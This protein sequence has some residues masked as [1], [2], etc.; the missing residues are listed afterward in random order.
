[1]R[2]FDAREASWGVRHL[3]RADAFPLV[4]GL[5]WLCGHIQLETCWSAPLA[6]RS[7][8]S[9]HREDR[10]QP[11]I[12]HLNWFTLKMI[13]ATHK[14]DVRSPFVQRSA[15]CQSSGVMSARSRPRRPTLKD[16]RNRDH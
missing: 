5:I 6:S 16:F 9:V 12:G 11:D 15:N 2:Q 13:L 4:A 7:L 10:T 1:M 3:Y 8:P 14:Y